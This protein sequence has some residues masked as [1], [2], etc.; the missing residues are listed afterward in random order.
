MTVKEHH[1]H[2]VC[3]FSLLL[4]HTRLLLPILGKQAG[5][6]EW[7]LGY[8]IG[9]VHWDGSHNIPRSLM[10]ENKHLIYSVECVIALIH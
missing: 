9:C 3:L 10:Y 5:R 7:L 8:D 1:Q 2:S 4:S 6:D